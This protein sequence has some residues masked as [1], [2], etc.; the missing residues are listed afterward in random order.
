M[1]LNP[2]AAALALTAED[3][4]A[5]L[6]QAGDRRGILDALGWEPAPPHR[7]APLIVPAAL[8]LAGAADHAVVRRPAPVRAAES[9]ERAARLVAFARLAV[10]RGAVVLIAG[11]AAHAGAFALLLLLH[12]LAAR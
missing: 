11:A 1:R 2:A 10:G 12:E 3:L 4:D 8:R 9:L 5:E 6:R 7:I